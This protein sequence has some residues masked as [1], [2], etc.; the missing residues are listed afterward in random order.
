MPH[1]E[2]KTTG[3]TPI[4]QWGFSF[5]TNPKKLDIEDRF[6][7]QLQVGIATFQVLIEGNYVYA[8]KT[9]S[10]YEMVTG[11]DRFFFLSRPRRFGKSL[12]LS[13]L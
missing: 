2:L 10:I 9:R 11:P 4:N 5:L 12:L 7:R 8:D 3:D 13:T 6:M 1:W